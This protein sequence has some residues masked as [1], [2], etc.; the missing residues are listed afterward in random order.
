MNP[1]RAVALA[2]AALA[3]L[4]VTALIVVWGISEREMHLPREAPLA[5]AAQRATR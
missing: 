3:V 5:A 2:C 4:A 1:L